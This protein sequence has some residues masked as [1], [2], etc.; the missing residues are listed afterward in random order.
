MSAE[1][2]LF[3]ASQIAAPGRS[4]RGVLFRLQNVAPDGELIVSS[5]RVKAWAFD[6]LPAEMRGELKSLARRQRD[7]VHMIWAPLRSCGEWMDGQ[8]L[9]RD[10]ISAISLPVHLV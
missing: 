10:W 8:S 7:V 1:P 3:S 9:A 5:S 6:S 2:S 4:R